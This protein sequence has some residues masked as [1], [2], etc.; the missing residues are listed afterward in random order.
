MYLTIDLERG[1]LITETELFSPEGERGV[2][3]GASHKDYIEV[4]KQVVG[5]FEIFVD[6]HPAFIAIEEAALH[7]FGGVSV[8][9]GLPQRAV[10]DY[11]G[12]QAPPDVAGEID[13]TVGQFNRVEVRAS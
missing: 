3:L 8:R 2:G 9:T 7:L 12:G 6:W 13:G 5:S 1:S 11:G 4:A 10:D